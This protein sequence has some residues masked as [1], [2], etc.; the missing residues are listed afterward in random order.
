VT[1][2]DAPVP[3]EPKSPTE[4]LEMQ[5][6]MQETVAG[7]RP[8]DDKYPYFPPDYQQPFL[9]VGTERQLFLDNYI[10]DWLDA[11]E[12]VFPVPERP[13]IPV[14]QANDYPWEYR[15]SP[16]PA[17][18]LQDPDTGTYKLWYVVPIGTDP[19]GDSNMALCYAE[20]DDCTHW[21]KPLSAHGQPFEDYTATNMV[22]TDSGHHLSVVV[23]PDRNNPERRYL[24]LYNPHDQARALGRRTMTTVLG[25]PD[26]IRWHMVN[27]H[28]DQ[29]HHHFQRI[30][31]DESIQKW[32][33][34]SQYSH[35][36]NPLHRR[37][38]IGRQESAD[39]MHWSPK[40]IVLSPEW[41]PAVAPN[42]EFHDMSVRKVGGTYIGLMAEFVAEP[43]WCSR[44]HRNWRDIAHTR[45]VLY[46]SRDGRRW[47]RATVDRPWAEHGPPGSCDY[48]FVAPSVSDQLVHEGKVYIFY[49][50][51]A[52]KQ[53]WFS[54]DPGADLVP[55][56]AA[57]QATADW[58]RYGEAMGG[59]P[60]HWSR[61]LN[62]FVLREDGWACLR[63]KYE[64]GRVYTQQ[65]V[66]EGD[67]IAIN[68]DCSGG[69]IQIEILD[70]YF[71]AYPGF[72]RGDSVPVCA[73]HTDQIW[74]TPRWQGKENLRELWNKPIRLVFHLHQSHLYSFQFRHFG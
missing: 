39:F 43:I 68:A 62:T 51:A 41:D 3:P 55:R 28:S 8:I 40:E 21:S 12:R 23:N 27:Q 61:T 14:L 15:E 6:R 54:R 34:Y 26:G 53:H 50:A 5:T 71:E 29:R 65:F 9:H 58:Q 7:H 22:L 11:V 74:H 63:P 1:T 30:L 64:A 66:F 20:S 36:W 72:G 10:L 49:H 48:G 31:W 59:Y 47:A 33:G 60:P 56:G 69:Y 44:D 45:Q 38:Q 73:D 2:S 70:P 25:S 46:S 4:P 18:A 32:I 13:R 57:V 37:R 52:D 16:W 42:V 35:H 19:F 24:L 17:A 67:E